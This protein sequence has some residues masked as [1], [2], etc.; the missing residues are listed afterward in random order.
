MRLDLL[1]RAGDA[2]G[3]G[4][5]QE[6]DCGALVVGDHASYPVILSNDQAGRRLPDFRAPRV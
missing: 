6:G 1:D 5:R 4:V 2:M 3:G